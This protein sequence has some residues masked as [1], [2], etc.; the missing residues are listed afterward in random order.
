MK[1]FVA[2]L[3]M[4]ILINIGNEAVGALIELHLRKI[5]G[6]LILTRDINKQLT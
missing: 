6:K 2:G 3:M 4:K 5:V 1:F